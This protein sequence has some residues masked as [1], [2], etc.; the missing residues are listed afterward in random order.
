MLYLL[1]VLGAVQKPATTAGAESLQKKL[2]S[3]QWSR[4]LTVRP[5]VSLRPSRFKHRKQTSLQLQQITACPSPWVAQTEGRWWKE[6]SGSILSVWSGPFQK[7]HVPSIPLAS[8]RAWA[9]CSGI[10]WQTGSPYCTSAEIPEPD[11]IWERCHHWL[12]QAYLCACSPCN[13]DVNKHCYP[14]WSSTV[15]SIRQRS[16]RKPRPVFFPSHAFTS[17]P[18]G[19]CLRWFSLLVHGVSI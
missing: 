5:S 12:G 4:V 19:S 17:D 1:L 6:G 13:K 11:S 14:H 7:D 8:S 3:A 16:D 15:I 18:R 9:E 2:V 10:W